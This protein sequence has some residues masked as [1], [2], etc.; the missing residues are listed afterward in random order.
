MRFNLE[1]GIQEQ[2]AYRKLLQCM[3]DRFPLVPYYMMQEWL[4]AFI[5][6]FCLLFPSIL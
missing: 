1:A 2:I 5:I 6:C 3:L 4:N